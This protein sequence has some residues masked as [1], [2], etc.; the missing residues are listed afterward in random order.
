[1]KICTKKQNKFIS[2]NRDLFI[3]KDNKLTLLGAIFVIYGTCKLLGMV[4]NE[5][6]K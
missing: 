1:M 4:K 3:D 2:E 6:E 5:K